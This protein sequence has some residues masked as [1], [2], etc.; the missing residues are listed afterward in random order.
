[1]SKTKLEQIEAEQ[2]SRP[3]VYAD[4]RK[5]S[6]VKITHELLKSGRE[7]LD[8]NGFIDVTPTMPHITRATGSCE[9]LDTTFV[10]EFYGSQAYLAQTEQLY[11]EPLVPLFNKVWCI[12]SSSRA[13]SKPDRR[14]LSE[15]CL[16]EFEE[17]KDPRQDNIFQQLLTDIETLIQEMVKGV[18]ER[19]VAELWILGVDKSRLELATHKF[20]R[21]SYDE[22]IQIVGLSWGD[23]LKSEHEQRI[24]ETLGNV[25]VFITHFPGKI[26]FF[27]MRDNPLNPKVV[28]SAD[29]ILPLAGET[30][31]AA[32]RE[33]DYSKVLYKLKHSRMFAQHQ[34]R[35]GTIDDFNYYLENLRLNGS[36]PHAGCG[37][38]LNRL[39]QFVCQISD[40]RLTTL[41]PIYMGSLY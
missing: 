11:L 31:G 33:Y 17:S 21:I 10:L 2:A 38:G 30:V 1:M 28:N 5:V 8:R 27:N 22:A 23:D 14:H 13:E 37:I 12:G 25:P 4:L 39:V 34:Q 24:I 15:F 32:E 19:A 20:P 41:Y 40:I 26:K 29:L 16:L 3:S 35:G 7:Y 6:I 9:N 18:I 36:I